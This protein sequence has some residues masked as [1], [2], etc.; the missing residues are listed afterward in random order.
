M[1]GMMAIAALLDTYEAW[2]HAAETASCGITMTGSPA[3]GCARSVRR[4]GLAE[5]RPEQQI[6]RAIHE[7]CA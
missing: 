5:G 6:V 3:P 1:T 2:V 4:R 7:H